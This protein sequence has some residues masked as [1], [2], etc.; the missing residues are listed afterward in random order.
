MELGA[1]PVQTEAAL[2][3]ALGPPPTGVPALLCCQGTLDW[4]YDAGEHR[5]HGS[6]VIRA[7][8]GTSV[9]RGTCV[10]PTER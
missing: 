1:L 9:Y 4:A 7:P 5:R 10:R 3:K 6:P 8:S 2:D